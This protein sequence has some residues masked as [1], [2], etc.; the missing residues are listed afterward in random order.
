MDPI[1]LTALTAK[2]IIGTIGTGL[3]TG[4][5]FSSIVNA[6]TAKKNRDFQKA[7]QDKN[8]ELQKDLQEKQQAFMLAVEERRKGS[9]KVRI[10]TSQSSSMG[11]RRSTPSPLIFAAQATLASPELMLW[12]I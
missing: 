12:A 6:I 10:S 8:H 7:M 3:A 5:G 1:T 11:V 4:M 2:V 9:S